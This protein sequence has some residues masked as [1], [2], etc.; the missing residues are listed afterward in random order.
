M[1][2][3]GSREGN[4]AQASF[5]H[6]LVGDNSEGYESDD[7]LDE[8][9]TP[10]N[11]TT[12]RDEPRRPPQNIN[13]SHTTSTDHESVFHR[14][15]IEANSA[16][17]YTNPRREPA[18]DLTS[19]S[20]GQFDTGIAA[21]FGPVHEM[22]DIIDNHAV[23]LPNISQRIFVQPSDRNRTTQ[24]RHVKSELTHGSDSHYVT[25]MFLMTRARLRSVAE[26][27]SDEGSRFTRV[28]CVGIN[29]AAIDRS[30]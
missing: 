22:F 4:F 18:L 27:E 29:S 25:V 2:V 5:T 9:Y 17:A 19:P 24:L 14:I 23:A 3:A 15:I 13:A 16:D 10:Q 26:E 7:E 20:D 30:V 28:R 8:R 1:E 11:Y 6:A 12:V 21:S